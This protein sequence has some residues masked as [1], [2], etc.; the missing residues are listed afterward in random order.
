MWALREIKHAAGETFTK[1]NFPHQESTR[2]V[3][4]EEEP[5]LLQFYAEN[6][7]ALA[8]T[9]KEAHNKMPES[10][11][12]ADDDTSTNGNADDDEM[13]DADG[14]QNALNV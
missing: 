14:Y 1:P 6:A 13:V 9:L 2:V 11:I 8:K 12:P 4:E 7:E 10:D 5:I 3:P